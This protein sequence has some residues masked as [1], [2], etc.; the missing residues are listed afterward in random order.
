MPLVTTYLVTGGAGFIGSHLVEALLNRGERVKVLD[1]FSTGPRDNLEQ[2]IAATQPGE[3]LVVLEGDL[4]DA[5]ALRQAVQGVDYILHHAAIVSVPGSVED[6][7]TCNEVNI[8]GT[9]QLLQ[10]AR[11]AGVRRLVL[12]SSSAVYGDNPALP[13]AETEIPAPLSPYAISKL[14][15]EQ[16][17]RAYYD[18]YGLETVALRYFNVFGP[19]QDPTSGY[20]A[21]IP[22]FVSATLQEQPVTIFGDG[23]QSRDFVYVGDVV[24]ANLL[25]CE[26]PGAAGQAINIAAG[27]RYSLLELVEALRTLNGKAIEV[28]H[29]PPRPGDI[30][31]SGADIN[32]AGQLLGFKPATGLSQGLEKAAAW[33]RAAGN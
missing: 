10:A 27:V 3:R 8:T 24:A 21:V 17:C 12:A 31:H 2:V 16:Y 11:E 6:P 13:L 4:R 28:R 23:L 9:L 26:A 18:L 7:L 15:G 29:V 5:S 32:K 14:T 30:K 1:N 33:Y 25:A 22:K 20:A 19:R